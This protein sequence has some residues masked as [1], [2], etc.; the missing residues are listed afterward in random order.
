RETAVKIPTPA[1]IAHAIGSGRAGVMVSGSH[2]PFDRNGIK[3]NKS[4]GEGLK[5]DEAG[6]VGEVE[7]LRAQEYGRSSTTSPF[8]PH[9][10]LK[11]T[12]ELPPVNAS[13]EDGYV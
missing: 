2:I 1:L 7:R 3:L 9:G 12:P 4:S 10:M 8:D 5:A 11:R 13:A 6:M